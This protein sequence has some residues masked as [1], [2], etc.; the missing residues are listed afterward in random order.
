MKKKLIAAWAEHV[1]GPGWS[2]S[3]VWYAYREENGE[4]KL[5]CLQPD[6]HSPEIV[7]LFSISVAVSSVFLGAVD[8]VVNKKK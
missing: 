7:N 2:N 6:E 5:G 1:A 8:D 3:P 4:I